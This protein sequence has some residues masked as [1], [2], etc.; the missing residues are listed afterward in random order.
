MALRFLKLFEFEEKMDKN[1]I[2]LASGKAQLNFNNVTYNDL[3]ENRDLKC[4]MMSVDLNK[5][6][7]LIA[8]PPCN[9]YSRARGNNPPSKYAIE[10]KHLLP[11]IIKKFLKTGKPF[12][13]ENVRNEP[14]FKKLGLFN[15][16]CFIYKHG[17]HTYW[18]NIMINFSTIPQEYEFKNKKGYGMIKLKKYIQGGKNVNDVFE[19]FLTCVC[20]GGIIKY[21]K[22][23]IYKKHIRK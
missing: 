11:E 2:Y 12:I 20:G 21:I 5:Y 23:K 19:Y 3:K 22:I 10:T 6:D 14:L 15:F 13:V 8:T 4:D 7:I 9:F 17:R 16:N 18:T 1:I